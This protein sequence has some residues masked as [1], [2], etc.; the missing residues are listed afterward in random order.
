MKYFTLDWPAY[1]TSPAC[2]AFRIIPLRWSRDKMHELSVILIIWGMC[3]VELCYGKPINR[4]WFRL[5]S[6]A[7]PRRWLSSVLRPPPHCLPRAFT[8][9]E[10]LDTLSILIWIRASLFPITTSPP[11]SSSF[12]IPELL[13][14]WPHS[15]DPTSTLRPDTRMPEGKRDLKQDLQD[16]GTFL[17]DAT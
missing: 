9:W 4:F 10:N 12:P 15:W 5:L 14:P 8:P 3:C 6:D 13:P 1:S 2:D 11:C 16:F 17:W 7:D